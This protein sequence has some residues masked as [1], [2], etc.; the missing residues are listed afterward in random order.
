MQ[1]RVEVNFNPHVEKLSDP[2]TF[3][4]ITP[5]RQIVIR[6]NDIEIW[7]KSETNVEHFRFSSN[8]SHMRKKKAVIHRQNV[9]I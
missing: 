5:L 2:K 4:R 1:K 6:I 3:K 8:L 7:A 9:N